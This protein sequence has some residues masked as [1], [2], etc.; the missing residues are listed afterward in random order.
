MSCVIP[1]RQCSQSR[2]ADEVVAEGEA[3]STLQRA[4]Y[5]GNLLCSVPIK[6]AFYLSEFSTNCLE[7][8]EQFGHESLSFLRI[9]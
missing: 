2:S 1:R 9:K 7:N 3:A 5:C 6:Y 4:L 8:G